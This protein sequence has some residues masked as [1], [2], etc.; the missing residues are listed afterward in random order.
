MLPHAALYAALLR[1]GLYG[2]VGLEVGH[3]PGHFVRY[4][5]EQLL[6]APHLGR[7]GGFDIGAEYRLVVTAAGA[8]VG[9]YLV[10]GV[11]AQC[12]ISLL[13]SYGGELL[14]ICLGQLQPLGSP[15]TQLVIVV[16]REEH[17]P[18][19]VH[20][21]LLGLA[22]GARVEAANARYPVLAEYICECSRCRT[23]RH[24][25]R[26]AVVEAVWSLAGIFLVG[27]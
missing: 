9:Q 19:V 15:L 1:V 21:S 27:V 7:Y 12:G 4:P 23:S 8:Q 6:V 25:G 18:Y 24:G 3:D 20:D 11:E 13:G 5:A 10:Y 22:L 16:E 14:G 17:V 2:R 26:H